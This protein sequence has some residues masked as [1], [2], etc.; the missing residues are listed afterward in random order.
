MKIAYIVLKGMPLGGGIEKYTE[1]VGS[2]LA[3]KGHRITIYAMR[4]Y[5]ARDGTY[6]D[7]EIHTVPTLK[8][9]SME[10]T[11]ASF[12]ATLKNSFERDIDIVHFHAFGPAMFCFLPRLLGKKVVVQGH[13]LEWKRSRWGLGGRFFLKLT[14]IPSVRFPHAVTVVS[15][16][17]RD[18]LKATY[19]RESIHIPTGVNF[20]QTEKPDLIRQYGL[21]GND[22]ILFAARLVREKGAHYLIEAYQQLKTT[23]IKLVIAG[24]AQHENNYK[25]ELRQLAG[26][27]KNIIFTGFITGKLLY[28]LF[29][30]CYIFVLPSEVEGLPTALLE[31]MSYGNCCLVSDIPENR[32]ALDGF[33]FYCKNKDVN[34]L[35]Y[36]LEYLINSERVVESVKEKAKNHVLENFLWDQIAIQ[37]ECLYKKLKN[38][39]NGFINNVLS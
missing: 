22:Y 26:N 29:S 18:Y 9:R 33:G 19:G 15:E 4:H 24:D 16:V 34:D 39:Q 14:E 25:G 6:K 11:A 1:E 21:H 8:F 17:Q 13:G 20:P 7:M 36:K 12:I 23:T 38:G 10:K 32:E 35:A 3:K 30:N 37:F 27:N 31:A 28:E 2:R 5:G